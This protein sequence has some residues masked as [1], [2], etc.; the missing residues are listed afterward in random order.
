MAEHV[1]YKSFYIFEARFVE[2]L[3]I[4]VLFADFVVDAVGHEIALVYFR[5]LVSLPENASWFSK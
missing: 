3:H 5:A 1:V 4:L 2:F